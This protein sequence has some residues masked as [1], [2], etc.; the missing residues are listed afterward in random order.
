MSDL[1]DQ[2]RKVTFDEDDIGGFDLDRHAVWFQIAIQV[3]AG[4]GVYKVIARNGNPFASRNVLEAL[5]EELKMKR[6]FPLRKY[7]LFFTVIAIGQEVIQ[8]DG[9]CLLPCL[10]E[11]RPQALDDLRL[12]GGSRPG[13]GEQDWDPRAAMSFWTLSMKQRSMSHWLL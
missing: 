12:P 2:E 4:G 8:L 6:L 1:L 7:P 9:S 5:F 10:F 13:N 3:V 11:R